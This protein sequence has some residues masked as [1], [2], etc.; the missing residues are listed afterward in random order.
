MI[1]L[2]FL[3]R[4]YRFFSIAREAARESDFRVHVGA[5]VVYKGKIIATG[6]SSE[7][8]SPVMMRFNTYR[9]FDNT[10]QI[11]HKLHAEVSALNKIKYMDIDFPKV[12]IYVWRNYSDKSPA[13]ARPCPACMAMIREMGIKDIYYTGNGSLVYERIHGEE[14][15][16]V[17]K[18]I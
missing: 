16:H 9:C 1:V 10:S 17:D 3:K 15:S 18:V 8:T 14:V 6:R 12:S 4:D 5:A 7:K 2:Q 11:Q 13:M